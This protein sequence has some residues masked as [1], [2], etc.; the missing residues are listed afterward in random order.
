METK[1]IVTLAVGL[2]LGTAA[3]VIG[4][5]LVRKAEKMRKANETQSET[6]L[7]QN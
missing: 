4:A 1:E 6:A 2:A 3:T 7:P 5:R